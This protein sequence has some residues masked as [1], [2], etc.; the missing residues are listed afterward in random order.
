MG[1]GGPGGGRPGPDPRVEG[2]AQRAGG[3]R[4]REGAERGEG[5]GLGAAWPARG[6]DGC[7]G[8]LGRGARKPDLVSQGRRLE[9]RGAM[10]NG[11]CAGRGAPRRRPLGG[12][13]AGPWVPFSLTGV[14]ETNQSSARWPGSLGLRGSSAP[15]LISQTC[16]RFFVCFNVSLGVWWSL[17]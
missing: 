10:T 5:R 6:G 4:G 17:V 8:L 14:G 1:E 15:G 9:M 13:S 7:P 3:G 16:V 2:P 11:Q 12:D